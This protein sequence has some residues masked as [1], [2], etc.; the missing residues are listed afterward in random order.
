MI[1]KV[2]I[3]EGIQTGIKYEVDKKI[4]GEQAAV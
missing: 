1:K 2:D 4:I 3:R